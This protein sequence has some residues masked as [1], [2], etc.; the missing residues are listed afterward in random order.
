MKER[1][2]YYVP[3]FLG[4]GKRKINVEQDAFLKPKEYTKEDKDFVLE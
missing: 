3:K 4:G 2:M 1:M